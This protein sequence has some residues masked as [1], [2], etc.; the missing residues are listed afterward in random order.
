[1][2]GTSYTEGLE[3]DAPGFE[4]GVHNLCSFLRG[5]LKTFI[6]FIFSPVDNDIYFTELCSLSKIT[7]VRYLSRLLG[8]KLNII[9]WDP[10]YFL[11]S[12][13]IL[14]INDIY[15][16]IIYIFIYVHFS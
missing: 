16:C 2:R 5:Q 9:V 15:A 1:M 4:F 10:F 11:P 6:N 3:S 12:P 14:Y 7:Y 13:N 8:T